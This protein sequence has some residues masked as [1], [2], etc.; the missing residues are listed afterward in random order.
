[1][2]IK[3]G[4]IYRINLEPTRGSEQQGNARPCV[5]LSVGAYNNKLPTVGVVPLS[6]SPRP[7]PPLIVPVPSAGR[8]TSMAVCNQV[9]TVDK[10]RIVGNVMGQLSPADLQKVESGVKQYYGL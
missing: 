10:R 4:E 6:S 3:R 9:R 7:L 5:I 8:D 2:A 1:M